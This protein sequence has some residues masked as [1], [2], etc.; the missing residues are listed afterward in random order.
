MKLQHY[1][2]KKGIFSRRIADIMIKQGFVKVD[3]SF[4]DDSIFILNNDHV[5]SFS[6]K[7]N[8]YA[9]SLGVL[10]FNK[11]RGVW[12]NCKQGK[13]EKEVLDFLPKIYSTYSSIGRLDK[14]SEGLILFTNDG[15]FAN[16]FLNAGE[17][18]E[19][20]YEVRTKRAL[21][22]QQLVQLQRGVMLTDG[23]TKPCKI[24][25]LKP[26]SYQF[27]LIEGKNRQIRR[28][29]EFCNTYVTSLKRLSFAQYQLKGIVSGQFKAFSLT[30]QFFRR[31]QTHGIDI[32]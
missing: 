22:T 24:I 17:S 13:H 2:S 7:I 28:M 14:D 29:V 31:L 11:P 9:D 19:R 6:K 4:I 10:L 16:Q 32:S 25:M 1:L 5:V 18:H 23:L 12:T 26:A 20:V 15:V 3:G 27:T 30:D 21:S 8:K